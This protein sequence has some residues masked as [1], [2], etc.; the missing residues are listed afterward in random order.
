MILGRKAPAFS[1]AQLNAE[2][3]ALAQY[4]ANTRGDRRLAAYVVEPVNASR[5]AAARPGLMLVEAVALLLLLVACTNIAGALLLNASERRPEFAVR[6]SMGATPGLLL[7]QI[8]AEMSTVAVVGVLLGAVLAFEVIA[9]LGSMAAPVLPGLPLSLTWRDLLAALLFGGVTLVLFGTVPA[10]AAAYG[11]SASADSAS[12][13]RSVY[14]VRAVL[15]V[16]QVGVTIVLL[17]GAT[18]LLRSYRSA[19]SSP[20]GFDSTGLLTTDVYRP[21]GGSGLPSF[22]D[23]V[24]ALDAS[25]AEVRFV[26]QVTF[27]DAS[28]FGSGG[29]NQRL[30]VLPADGSDAVKRSFRVCHVSSNYFA[31]LHIGIVRG[32]TFSSDTADLDGVVVNEAFART[33]RGIEVLGSVVR[34]SAGP[35]QIIGV[36]A[37]VKSTWLT[38]ASIP[39]L[40]APIALAASPTISVTA[41]S[42]R[43]SEAAAEM[44]KAIERTEP[45]GPP[46]AIE[47]LST[48]VWRSEAKRRFYLA[49]AG[50]FAVVAALVSA[51]G[52]FSAVG[53]VVELRSKDFAIRIALGARRLEILRL[54]LAEGLQPVIIA[55]LAGLLGAVALVRALAIHPFSQALLFNVASTDLSTYSLPVAVV[56]ANAALACLVPIKRALRVDPA[57]TLKAN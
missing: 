14:K 11:C 19:M 7:R 38:T 32:R 33:L 12:P 29:S 26:D 25:M 41:R 18:V 40:Y 34:T 3:D 49:I 47:P 44:R 28:P 53:R 27:S 5:A 55:T 15:L 35:F 8:L 30:D 2:Y 51:L 56:F 9:S 24:R 52:I 10:L 17:S 6:M 39:T 22:Q 45:D 54:V 16:C 4:S 23:A 50:T 13:K 20:A 46:V 43:P 48:I 1:L 31:L 36:V 42:E 21:N 37:D 57:T